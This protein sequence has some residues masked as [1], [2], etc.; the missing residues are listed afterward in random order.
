ML[1]VGVIGVGAMGRNHARVYSEIQG[2]ELVGVADT[3]IDQA[4]SVAHQFQTMAFGHFDD[5]LQCNL[6]AVS[7]AVP[8]TNHKEIALEAA[9]A[10][11]HMLIEKPIAHTVNSACE[12]IEASERYGV[13]LMV[14]HIERFNP[15][16]SVIKR[17]LT[18]NEIKNEINLI[19]I[20]RIGPFPPRIKDVGVIIDLAT[21]DIDLI[22]Y[23]TSSECECV[24]SL[25]ANNFTDHE[26][27]AVIMLKMENGILARITVNWLTP[28]KVREINVATKNKYIKG[29]LIDQKVATYSSYVANDS[30]L[31]KEISVPFGEPLKNEISAFLNCI[32]NNTPPPVSGSDGL[33][34][35]EVA[36][37]CLIGPGCNKELIQQWS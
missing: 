9:R 18:E 20:T 35:L 4:N 26:D 31:V 30:Y 32:Q 6:N 13:K 8:S 7:I 22:R 15:V 12:I 27:V 2:V 29:S 19:E 21:H 11:V 33:L 23:L 37:K 36:T 16:V 14:G 24:F 17:E 5:L 10:G 25:K 3:N 1:R 28:F 34:A